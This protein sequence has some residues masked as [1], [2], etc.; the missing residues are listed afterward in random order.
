MFLL[1]E[2]LIS[3]YEDTYKKCGGANFFHLLP[4]F[5]KVV[6][7][8]HMLSYAYGNMWRIYSADITRMSVAPSSTEEDAVKSLLAGVILGHFGVLL[9]M[10][11]ASYHDHQHFSLRGTYLTLLSWLLAVPGIIALFKTNSA[12]L[13][14]VNSNTS[15][16]NTTWLI[17]DT[18]LGILLLQTGGMLFDIVELVASAVRC[19]FSTDFNLHVSSI[20]PIYFISLLFSFVLSRSLSLSLCLSVS[21]FLSLSV[22]IFLSLFLSPILSFLSNAS[23]ISSL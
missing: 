11:G 22:C 5:S 2:V 20:L 23:T 6:A 9:S 7:R 10:L 1:N 8:N 17:V 16:Y 21:F 3:G 19:L 15:V 14:S 4:Y 12:T 18:A 13:E